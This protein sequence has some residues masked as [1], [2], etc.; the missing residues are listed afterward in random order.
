MIIG[1]YSRQPYGRGITSVFFASVTIRAT[2]AGE[3]RAFSFSKAAVVITA[4]G[5]GVIVNA[6]GAS[7]AA[8]EVI[9]LT[10]GQRLTEDLYFIE[11]PQIKTQGV[12]AT[13]VTVRSPTAEYTAEVP[14][15]PAEN[16]IERVIEI[17]EGNADTCEAVAE[18]LL[19]RWGR[20][21]LSITGRVPLVVTLRFKEFVKV[22]I[23]VSDIDGDYILQRKEHDLSNFETR[24]TVGDIILSDDELMARIME[25]LDE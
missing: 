9:A 15:T 19:E 18:G 22:F 24:I 2:G 6:T 23:P 3:K 10:G 20:E 8:V 5:A 14:A 11:E 7:K 4:T 16:T 12:I 21:Q 13:H 17:K 25:E 1:P